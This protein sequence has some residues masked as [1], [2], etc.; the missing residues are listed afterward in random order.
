VR[1]PSFEELEKLAKEGRCVNCGRK[2]RLMIPLYQNP[3]PE[4]FGD[5]RKRF[6]KEAVD[7]L[8]K[9]GGVCVECSEI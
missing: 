3:V 4:I 7:W 1:E 8:L 5:M 2:A 6:T 9:N